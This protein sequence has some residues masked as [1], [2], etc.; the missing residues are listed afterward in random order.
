MGTVIWI[1][2]G[3]A[4]M[5]FIWKFVMGTLRALGEPIAPPPEPGELRKVNI[6]FRC[7]VCGTELK[8]TLTNDDMPDPPRHCLED[9]I[10]ITPVE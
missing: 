9:M 5:W 6:K 10:L 2:I 8:M 4:L 7:D 1:A 3:V